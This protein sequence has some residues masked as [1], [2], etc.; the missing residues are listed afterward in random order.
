M[1]AIRYR[2]PQ[3][4]PH[5]SNPYKEMSPTEGQNHEA[6]NQQTMPVDSGLYQMHTWVQFNASS[7]DATDLEI[8]VSGGRVR[9]NVGKSFFRDVSWR[10]QNYIHPFVHTRR[11]DVSEDGGDWTTEQHLNDNCV[12]RYSVCSQFQYQICRD[13]HIQ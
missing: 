7:N 8:C 9:A 5:L 2:Q 3:H 6:L 12:K 4:S 1:Y 10:V 11:F 13:A